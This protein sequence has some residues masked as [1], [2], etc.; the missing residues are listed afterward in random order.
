MLCLSAI[1]NLMLIVQLGKRHCFA[2]NMH[3]GNHNRR[4][5]D[6]PLHNIRRVKEMRMNKEN[7]MKARL[8]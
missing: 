3:G 2:V 4:K 6:H 5:Y 1:V 8:R 7:R